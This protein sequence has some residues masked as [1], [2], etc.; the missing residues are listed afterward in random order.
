ME[1]I[2]VKNGHVF[3]RARDDEAGENVY[4]L[5][6]VADADMPAYPETAPGAGQYYALD[7]DGGALAWVT[8]SRPLTTEERLAAMEEELAAAKILLGVE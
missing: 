7:Y 4:T 8:K 3:A 1:L 2:I 6:A 5:E